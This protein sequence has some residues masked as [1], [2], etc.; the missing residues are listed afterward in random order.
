MGGE[1]NRVCL[2][3]WGHAIREKRFKLIVERQ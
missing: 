2:G 3:D 1:M